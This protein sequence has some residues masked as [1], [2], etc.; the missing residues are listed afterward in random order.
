M[1]KDAFD[2][3]SVVSM[4]SEGMLMERKDVLRANYVKL[5]VQ[6]KQLLSMRKLEKMVLEKLHD[7]ILI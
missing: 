6:R 7:T 2:L 5:F 3:D 4:L 1:K